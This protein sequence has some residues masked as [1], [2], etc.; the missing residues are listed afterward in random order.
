MFKRRDLL[1]GAAGGG[2]LALGGRTAGAAERVEPLVN[3]DGLYTQP[4]F[5]HSFLDLQEDLAEAAD[6]GKRLAVIWEQKGC[7]YCKEM[8]LVNFADPEIN[9]YVRDNF[10]ILQ[11]NIHGLRETVDFDGEVL[12]ER[13]MARRWGIRF[14]PTVHFF[15]EDP[16]GAAGQV[17][18][19]AEVARMPGYF[20][21]PHFLAMFRYVREKAYEEEDFRAFLKR[22]QAS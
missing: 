22:Q 11:L 20:K 18:I 15:P 6:N 17:G 13:S 19:E 14:T 3:D 16:E 5:L 8:H 12:D 21:P 2:L 7:P 10:E 4:W 9:A 1:L